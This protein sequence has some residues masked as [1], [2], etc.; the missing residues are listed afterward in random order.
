MK[1]VIL[2]GGHGLRLKPLTDITNKHLIAIGNKPMI[3]YPLWTLLRAGITD[4]LIVSGREHAGQF[5]EFLGSGADYKAKFTFKVQEEAGGIAQALL[6]AEDFAN[7]S[8]VTVIL[9]DNIFADDISRYTSFSSG[10]RIFLKEVDDPER[11]GVAVFDENTKK[12]SRIWEKPDLAPTRF[13]VTGL[14]QYDRHVFDFIRGLRPSTRGELEITDVNNRYIREGALE[15][16][17]IEGFWTDAGTFNS[18]KAA[19]LWAFENQGR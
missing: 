11:F 6:L 16:E 17:I 2:A 19:T 13:A 14:Y 1:G 12:V 5:V 7:G 15:A 4:I 3:V 9:G 10:A 18:L 8:P